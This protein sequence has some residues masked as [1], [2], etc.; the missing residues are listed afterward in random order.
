MLPLIL[1][2][3]LS[4]THFFSKKISKRIE[5]YHTNIVSF[6]AGIFITIIF[7]FLLPEVIQ[8]YNIVNV[9][10]IMLVGFVLF[11]IT[12]KYLY[13]HVK[14]KKVLMKDLAELHILGFFID[15]FVIG[16]IL[17]L[18]FSIQK[19]LD[20]ILFIPFFLHTVS[21]SL[22]LEHIDEKSKTNIN[23]II[24]ASSTFIGALFATALRLNEVLFYS[25]FSL[26]I[27]MLFYI[28]IRDMLPKDKVGDPLSF[29]IGVIITLMFVLFSFI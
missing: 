4:I 29:L 25:L 28:A 10:L 14:N 7:I 20:Y 27:G 22:S 21:S 26:T 9:Y 11:H 16:I 3:I 23:K 1:A 19:Q 12:E 6:S 24:L 15:H 8:G 17:V 2:L 13:Q 5:K 18:I